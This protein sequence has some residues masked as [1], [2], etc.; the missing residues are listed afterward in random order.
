MFL[1]YETNSAFHLGEPNIF[2]DNIP[3]YLYEI[4]W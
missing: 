3:K 1:E 4:N 2:Q